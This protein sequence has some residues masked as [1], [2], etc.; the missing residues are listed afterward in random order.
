[1][2]LNG[3]PQFKFTEAMSFVINCKDQAEV[4]MYWEKLSEGGEKSVCGWLKDKF[5][6]SWQV[7]PEIMGTFMTDP[8]PK[9][10]EA[11][12]TAMLKMTKMDV[13][14]LQEAYDQA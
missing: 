7:I 9:K 3:G 4:D 11:A 1:M 12:M 10:V 2:A 14:K 13:A 5:G 8:N 6:L